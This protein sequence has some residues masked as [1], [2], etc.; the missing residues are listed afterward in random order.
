MLSWFMPLDIP[1]DGNY[2]LRCACGRILWMKSGS[3]IRKHHLGHKMKVCE[4]GSI[5]EF[6]KMKTG[7]I[8]SRTFGEWFRDYID[9]RGS[10]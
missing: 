5:V 8:N 1:E 7:L 10:K 3:T 2:L 6:I 4:T 9:A